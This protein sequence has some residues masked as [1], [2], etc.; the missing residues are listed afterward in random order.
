LPGLKYIKLFAHPLFIAGI[1][2]LASAP[3]TLNLNPKYKAKVTQTSTFGRP[4]TRVLWVDL[5]NNGESEKMEWF[6]NS[7]GKAAY[8]ITSQSGYILDQQVFNGQSLTMR[9]PPYITN[10]NHNN[11]PEIYSF[12]HRNDSLF[13]RGIEYIEGKPHLI[14][15]ERYVSNV[16]NPKGDYDYSGK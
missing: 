5:D 8:K 3:F 10:L 4:N 6:I 7:E 15:K 16:D 9:N 2:V 12:Y 1:L 11:I 14:V 13:I